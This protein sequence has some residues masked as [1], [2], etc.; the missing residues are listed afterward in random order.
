[1]SNTATASRQARCSAATPGASSGGT[2]RIRLLPV[3]AKVRR[4]WRAPIPSSNRSTRRR[5]ADAHTTANAGMAARTPVHGW[6]TASC[7]ACRDLGDAVRQ[8]GLVRVEARE[9]AD[10]DRPQVECRLA[11]D[12][13]LG[14]RLAGA[15]ARGDAHRI[16]AAADVQVVDAGRGS[17][18]E[19]V[20]GR[21]QLGAVVELLD[22]G[23]LECR[24]ADHRIV[25]QDLEGV[26]VV[27]QQLELEVLGDPAAVLRALSQGVACG[28]KPPISS[29]PTS[30]L[31]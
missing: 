17:E 22:L 25:E 18:D 11:A 24:H 1:M 6:A 16:E 31:K 21:E 28:S 14:E 29:P 2:S 4:S 23:L 19:V 8:P 26:P 20:V 7:S 15:A 30:S 12:D 10:V 5:R 13:P 3:L 9:A 27:R